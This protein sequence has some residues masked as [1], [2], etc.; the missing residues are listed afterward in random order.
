MSKENKDNKSKEWS[1]DP[2][3]KVI[4]EFSDAIATLDQLFYNQL[5]KLEQTDLSYMY[6]KQYGTIT[7]ELCELYMELKAKISEKKK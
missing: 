1:P 6:D 5:E 2:Q 4:N 7:D 3:Q